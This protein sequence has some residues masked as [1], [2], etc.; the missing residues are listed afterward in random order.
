[1]VYILLWS[2]NTA[3]SAC[4]KYCAFST[5]FRRLVYDSIFEA[6]ENYLMIGVVLT[7]SK[8]KV[9][10]IDDD[11]LLCEGF[12]LAFQD[13]YTLSIA[14]NYEEGIVHIDDTVSVVVLDIR[15]QHKNGFEICNEIKLN[16]PDMLIIFFS[17]YPEEKD[18]FK[19][20]NDHKPFAFVVKSGDLTELDNAIH[21]AV[22]YSDVLSERKIYK[23]LLDE[24]H[25]NFPKLKLFLEKSKNDKRALHDFLKQYELALQQNIRTSALKD[26][27]FI[28]DHP[29]YQQIIEAAKKAINAGLNILVTGSAGVGKTSIS[30]YIAS[31]F[32]QHAF[33]P[34]NCRVEASQQRGLFEINDEMQTDQALNYKKLLLANEGILCLK[35]MG[36]LSVNNQLI[37]EEI[38]SKKQITIAGKAQSLSFLIVAT[39][40]EDL[41]EKCRDGLFNNTLYDCVKFVT[42]DIPSINEIRSVI[43]DF[44]KFFATL[45]SNTAVQLDSEVI[46]YF[47]RKDWVENLRELD[48]EVRKYIQTGKGQF[49]LKGYDPNTKKKLITSALKKFKF[50]VKKTAD[51]LGMKRPNLYKTIETMGIKTKKRKYIK[52]I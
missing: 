48:F 45:Y 49:N 52:K 32:P 41:A 39:T 2:Q 47:Q 30:N 5:L 42:L 4:T 16:Y 26:T 51:Y 22:N 3:I 37:L 28:P 50:N 17:A 12:K 27:Y 34:I 33:V 11:P 21:Q 24:V 25:S 9:V 31:C 43:P 46:H 15:M 8:K 44:V 40:T 29:R 1:M 13:Q 20:I 36:R 35:E 6:A 7:M 18:P 14:H 38:I 10:L 19:V 23:G